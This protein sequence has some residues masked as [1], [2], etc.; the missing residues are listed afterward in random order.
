MH[1]QPTVIDVAAAAGVSRQTVSNVLNSPEIVRPET[2][3]R[4]E[5]AI[6]ELGYLP[7]ASARRLRTRRSSTIGIRLDHL[8]A[9]GISGSVLDRFLHALTE[10]AA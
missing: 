3:E 10:Q 4:V 6:Q 8:A 1:S 2:R 9:D 7:H 5:R